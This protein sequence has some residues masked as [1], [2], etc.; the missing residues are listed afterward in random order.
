MS[1]F[2]VDWL[3]LLIRWAHLIAGIGWIGTSF[4][5]VALDLSLK[6][7]EKMNPGVFGTAWEVHGGGFY[8]VEK[9]L[10]AP[11]NLPDGLIWYKWEAY[12]T[13][14]SGFLLMTVQFYLNADLWLIDASVMALEPWQAISISVASLVTGWLIYDGL[15]R[16]P[17]GRNTPV[18]A[19]LVFILILAAAY[20]Y[21]HIFSGRSALVHVGA[22]IGTMMAVNVFGIIIPN[23]KKITASLLAGEKPDPK[24]GV[25]G[26]Q[27]STHNTYLTLPVLVMMV[28]GHYAMLTGHPQSWMLVGLIVIAGAAARHFL[29]RHE[30][31]DPMSKIGWALPVIAIA[32]GIAM[33]ITAP[34]GPASSKAVSNE[35]VAAIT[36]KHCIMCHA[37]KPS[38]ESFDEAPKG[39]KL[40][41]LAELRKF[42]PLVL[43]QA[44]ET[45]TM[46]L[47]NETEMT[48]NERQALGR[49]LKSK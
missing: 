35:Q 20:F 41:T 4:Y 22:F 37:D 30:V 39:V 25:I 14:I 5:F 11:D 49:W 7:R 28:S 44:V 21:T 26:K 6:K 42:A 9:Y 29:L 12:L 38:H 48:N 15:C 33:W 31:G 45:Q 16:S 1:G 43:K 2:L 47:G 46:P 3:N 27:R 40:E 17:I 8:H 34:A 10:N 19:G 13:W 32:L 23:Q 18:L 24:F 36:S